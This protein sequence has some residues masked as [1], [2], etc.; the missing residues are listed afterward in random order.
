MAERAEPLI[1][2]TW[3]RNAL[4]AL[5]IVH[6]VIHA[7]GPLARWDLV[8]FEDIDGV[9]TV[10]ISDTLADALGVVWLIALVLFVAAGIAVLLRRKWWV[11]VSLIG[12]AISQVLVVLWWEGAWRGTIANAL[13]LA[14]VWATRTRDSD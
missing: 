14:V 12:V 3:F 10:G 13:V 4:A 7:L 8:E 5:L 6:G 2:R 9:P 1:E 11:P